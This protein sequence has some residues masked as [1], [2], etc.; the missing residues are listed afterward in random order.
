MEAKTHTSATK[1]LLNMTDSDTTDLTYV[2]S[3]SIVRDKSARSKSL[4]FP[5]YFFML[6]FH[7]CEPW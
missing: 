5:S 7:L 1:V 4:A 6:V 2:E 3:W